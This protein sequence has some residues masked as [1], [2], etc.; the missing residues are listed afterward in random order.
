[1]F[2][3]LHFNQEDRERFLIGFQSPSGDSLF[4][5]AQPPKQS[6]KN[7]S[8]FQSPSGDSLFSDYPEQYDQS[9]YG[10]VVSIP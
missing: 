4:S 7:I 5:D 6:K 8:W 2:S 9:A 1:M 3:D 10:K